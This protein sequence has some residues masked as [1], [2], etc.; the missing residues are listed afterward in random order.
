M[1]KHWL[2][3]NRVA[4][5][6]LFAFLAVLIQTSFLPAFEIFGVKPNLPLALVVCAALREGQV[7]AGLLGFVLGMLCDVLVG[8]LPG[9]Y[10]LFFTL[11]GAALGYAAQLLLRDTMFTALTLCAGCEL[12]FGTLSFAVLYLSFDGADLLSA[13]L[14]KT[15]PGALYTLLLVPPCRWVTD[16]AYRISRPK[17]TE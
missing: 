3:F 17:A 9:F 11:L 6:G 16:W 5:Y 7:C 15:L 2:I 10:M 4:A 1:R 13:S 14:Q 8:P 12:L